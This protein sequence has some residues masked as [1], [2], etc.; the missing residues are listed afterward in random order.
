MKTNDRTSVPCVI[1]CKRNSG[2]LCEDFGKRSYNAISDPKQQS[3]Q[4]NQPILLQGFFRVRDCF[5]S[6]VVSSQ[7]LFRVRVCFESGFVSSP[8]LFQVRV[9]FGSGVVSSQGLFRV[10]VCFGSGMRSGMWGCD[11]GTMG[12]WD[13]GI[14]G[15]GS[16]NWKQESLVEILGAFGPFFIL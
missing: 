12:Q 10:R 7:G 4:K 1:P 15:L 14:M 8:G 3:L 13:N 16:W 9:C 11:N 2:F 6:G 5:E